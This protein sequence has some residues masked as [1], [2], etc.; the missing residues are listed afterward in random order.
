M[1]SHP[2]LNEELNDLTTLRSLI[3]R[4]ENVVN[5]LQ[6]MLPAKGAS[7]L[8]WRCRGL[9]RRLEDANRELHKITEVMQVRLVEKAIEDRQK[10]Q[11]VIDAQGVINQR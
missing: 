6:S 7:W 5:S 11:E 9:K 3:Q 1:A 10:I 2:P 4:A 8:D